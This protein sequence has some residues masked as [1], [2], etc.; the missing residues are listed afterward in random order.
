MKKNTQEATDTL[1]VANQ[2][3]K[4]VNDLGETIDDSAKD[5]ETLLKEFRKFKKD[6]QADKIQL[7][8]ELKQEVEMQIKPLADELKRLTKTKPRFIFIKP[9]MPRWFTWMFRIDTKK[10]N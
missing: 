4:D 7:K 2:T 6:Y 10:V 9:K 5:L 3:W 1:S 8:E